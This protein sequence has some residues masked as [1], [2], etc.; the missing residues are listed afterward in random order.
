MT[1]LCI[2]MHLKERHKKLMKI[3]KTYLNGKPE[4]NRLKQ[5]PPTKK[6]LTDMTYHKAAK[7][8][9][10]KP[11][12]QTKKGL[13]YQLE[14]VHRKFQ[15]IYP[16]HRRKRALINALGSIVK[17]ISGNLDQDDAE[18]YDSAISTLQRNQVNVI[19]RMNRHVSL[20]TKLIENFNTTLN[21]ITH[22]QEVIALEIEKYENAPC[23]N[24]NPGYLC[25]SNSI[26]YDTTSKNCIAQILRLSDDAA[27]YQ[28][29]PVTINTTPIEQLTPGHYIAL[30]PEPTKISTHCSATGILVLHGTFL[31]ELPTGC[32]FKTPRD[33][34]INS[35][36]VIREQ[37]L[38]LP[39]IKTVPVH[40][41]EE[42]KPIHS[43]KI[44]LDELHKLH[45]IQDH[46]TPLFYE[47]D[48]DYTHLWTTPV[49]IAIAASVGILCFK[50]NHCLPCQKKGTTTPPSSHQ[51]C[52]SLT[53]LFQ[54]MEKLQ[55]DVT[56]SQQDATEDRRH[57]I[58]RAPSARDK[59]AS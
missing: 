49:Y 23:R 10:L 53:K 25:H 34:H 17:A 30:F 19:R 39:K 13:Q 31:I 28:H 43:E 58:P 33:A 22:N 38:T 52:S 40:P 42:I 24:I 18:K 14:A 16:L 11:I 20:T 12:Q 48:S 15:S 59:P 56:L 3:D 7:A 51:F 41:K 8:I 6:Y 45:D 37:P 9:T 32:G 50:Y 44:P 35:K 57:P 55:N 36:K 26:Q 4:K 54:G 29:V 27:F 21:L 47:Q 46:M 5:T 1:H 2:T